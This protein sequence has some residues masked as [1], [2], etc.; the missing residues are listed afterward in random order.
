MKTLIKVR[1]TDGNLEEFK[2]EDYRVGHA[3]L[4]IK[5]ENGKDRWIPT[6]NIRWFSTED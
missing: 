1:W 3:Y 4:W 5:M 2:A 6:L